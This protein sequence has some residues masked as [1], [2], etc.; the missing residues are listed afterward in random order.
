MFKTFESLFNINSIAV[1]PPPSDENKTIRDMNYTR[2]VKPKYEKAM[3]VCK[4][5]TGT[6][7]ETSEQIIPMLYLYSKLA[8]QR[9]HSAIPDPIPHEYIDDYKTIESYRH[10]SMSFWF[11]FRD[12]DGLY[13]GMRDL[14]SIVPKKT[15]LM[16]F[17]TFH[18]GI[19]MTNNISAEIKGTE[20]PEPTTYD[21]T[22]RY[23]IKNKYLD[24]TDIKKIDDFRDYVRKE[25]EPMQKDAFIDIS[26]N[27]RAYML[28]KN[29]N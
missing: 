9:K 16:A 21:F 5:W 14:S 15:D 22:Q 8:A 13:Y 24:I 2:D 11:R 1:V 26:E 28:N 25:F 7:C 20:G 19:Y 3:G 6:P 27:N 17:S 12:T 23:F 4:K 10:A 29:K 18:W